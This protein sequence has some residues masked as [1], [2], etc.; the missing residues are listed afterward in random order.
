MPCVNKIMEPYGKQME[1]TAFFSGRMLV[2]WSDSTERNRWVKAM[3]KS[4]G[5]FRKEKLTIWNKRQHNS[6]PQLLSFQRALIPPWG[7]MF[8]F[9]SSVFLWGSEKVMSAQ[10]QGWMPFNR[11]W[12]QLWHDLHPVPTFKHKHTGHSVPSS[13]FTCLMLTITKFFHRLNAEVVTCR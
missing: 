6:W 2:N 11:V 5:L 8:W 10:R 4:S 13:F 3:G 1:L 7:V 9:S 12:G